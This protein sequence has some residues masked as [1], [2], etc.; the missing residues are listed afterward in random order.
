MVTDHRKHLRF[1]LKKLLIR[2]QYLK[3]AHISLERV[4]DIENILLGLQRIQRDLANK[5]ISKNIRRYH[6]KD[7]L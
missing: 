6:L 3:S 1:I 7:E 4:I 5:K 2:L